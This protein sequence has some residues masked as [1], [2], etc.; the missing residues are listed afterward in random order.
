MGHFHQQRRFY[1][2]ALADII[3]LVLFSLNFPFILSKSLSHR[4]TDWMTHLI[5]SFKISQFLESASPFFK[6]QLLYIHI[7]VYICCCCSHT[8]LYIYI[9]GERNGNP[10]Q[11]SCLENPRDGGAWW[12]A[13]YEVAQ[14]RTQLK[15]LS[16]SSIY[17]YIY[18]H[19]HTHTHI[20]EAKHINLFLE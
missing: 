16:S 8:L 2:T 15:R 6:L 17:I 10:L 20:H 5:S 7:Y 4:I 18:T 1:W 12:A 9:Y 19:T 3:I 14:S 11:Y 13:V